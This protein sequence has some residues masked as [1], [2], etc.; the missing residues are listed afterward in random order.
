MRCRKFMMWKCDYQHLRT[1]P[2][3]GDNL[4]QIR[5]QFLSNDVRAHVIVGNNMYVHR[6]HALIYTMHGEKKTGQQLKT[7]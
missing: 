3:C 1:S 7:Y 4:G 6:Q 2:H 5:E